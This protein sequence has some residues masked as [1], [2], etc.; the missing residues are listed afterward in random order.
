MQNRILSSIQLEY[1]ECKE[2]E[3]ERIRISY[4]VVNAYSACP[5]CE[6]R[7]RVKKLEAQYERAMIAA[8]DLAGLVL[9]RQK[10]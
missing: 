3:K 9:G 7:L 6:A 5:L 1:T 2:H 4:P 8:H 10:N